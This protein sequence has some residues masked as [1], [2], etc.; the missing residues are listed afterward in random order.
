[1]RSR[2]NAKWCGHVS[3]VVQ[4]PKMAEDALGPTSVMLHVELSGT[5]VGTWIM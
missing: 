5:G 3:A 1:M 2:A 4:S